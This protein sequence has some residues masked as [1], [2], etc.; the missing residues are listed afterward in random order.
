[1]PFRIWCFTSELHLRITLDSEIMTV[2]F[3]VLKSEIIHSYIEFFIYDTDR[4]CILIFLIHSDYPHS[5]WSMLLLT[6]VMLKISRLVCMYVDCKQNT[7]PLNQLLKKIHARIVPF[8]G[9]QN[10]KSRKKMFWD[11]DCTLSTGE[12]CFEM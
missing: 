5:G 7:G 6:E 8:Q 11:V 12:R 3:I 1:M 4:W 2:P 10:S 9:E